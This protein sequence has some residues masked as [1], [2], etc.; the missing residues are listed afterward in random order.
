MPEGGESLI[1]IFNVLDAF[2]VL[3]SSSTLLFERLEMT[4]YLKVFG[5]KRPKGPKQ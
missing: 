3:L 1:I 2:L 5:S 4:N